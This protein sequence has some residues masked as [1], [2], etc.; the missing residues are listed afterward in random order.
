M[1]ISQIMQQYN[2]QWQRCSALY[3]QWAESMGITYHELLTL[4]SLAGT[5]VCTPKVVSEQWTLPKQTVHSVL[6][7]FIKKGWIDMAGLESDGRGKR[8]LLTEQGGA[9]LRRIIGALDRRERAVQRRLGEE[10]ALKLVELTARFN[11]C[12]AEEDNGEN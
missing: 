9:A 8:I 3:K 1:Q 10:N 5:E 6:C 12:F 2:E 7:S 11:S 4:I